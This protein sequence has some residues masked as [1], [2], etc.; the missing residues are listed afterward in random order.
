[1]RAYRSTVSMWATCWMSV[2]MILCTLVLGFLRVR[3]VLELLVSSNTQGQQQP[4]QVGAAAEFSPWSM[5]TRRA[6]PM[7]PGWR[8]A[9]GG[10][11]RRASNSLNLVSSLVLKV[12]S[13]PSILS[14]ASPNLVSIS[15]TCS[16][17]IWANLSCNSLFVRFSQSIMS[18][19]DPA[20]VSNKQEKHKY[21]VL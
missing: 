7:V 21:M 18:E 11:G 1:M 16:V 2:G 14:M 12:F 19:L 5:R 6:R 15:C 17:T 13:N 3:V 9:A 8:C 4:A 10:G 20:M